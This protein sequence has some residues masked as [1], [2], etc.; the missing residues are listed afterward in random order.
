ML[1]LT[2]KYGESIVIDGIIKVTVEKIKGNR[3]RLSFDAP[4]D[5]EIVRGELPTKPTKKDGEAA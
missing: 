5:I 3:I 1:V 4:R 2:R